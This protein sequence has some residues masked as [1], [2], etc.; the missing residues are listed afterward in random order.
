[1]PRDP[2]WPNRSAGGHDWGRWGEGTGE[3]PNV[4]E[5]KQECKAKAIGSVESAMCGPI[6]GRG[7]VPT[8]A[9]H[10]REDWMAP[11]GE[12]KT[13]SQLGCWG[14]LHIEP[15][16]RFGAGVDRA[17]APST[18][19]GGVRTDST[20]FPSERATGNLLVDLG[21]PSSGLIYSI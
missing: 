8:H 9:T 18:A 17:G 19:G 1:M 16:E 5:R 6:G 15:A 13:D 21:L 20:L 2:F 14:N 7:R 10:R 11:W 12:G 4:Q 3:E